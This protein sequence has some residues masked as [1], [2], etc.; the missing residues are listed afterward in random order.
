MVTPHAEHNI[1]LTAVLN[2]SSPAAARSSLP[3]IRSMHS[4]RW[5][6]TCSFTEY[7]Q[8]Q[9]IPVAGDG[10]FAAAIVLP[11]VPI[12]TALLS[13]L[14][15]AVAA[16]SPLLLLLPWAPQ[17]HAWRPAIAL[18]HGWRVA[19]IPCKQYNISRRETLV[20]CYPDAWSAQAAVAGRL[21]HT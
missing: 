18:V 4:A 3:H 2:V 20:S 12:T 1:R 8:L 21:Q 17:H 9:Q 15:L 13:P 7:T 19:A 16:R 10:T 6:V 5:P 14:L 11:I